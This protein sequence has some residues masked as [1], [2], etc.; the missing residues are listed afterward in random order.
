MIH[1][2]LYVTREAAW[3]PWAVQ[4]FF[5]I[6]LSVGC[7]LLTLP[8]LALGWAAWARLSRLALLGALV[9]GVTAP[10]AL[11]ADLHQPGRFMNFYLRPNPTSWMAWGAFFI[12]LYLGGLFAYAWA[13]LRPDFLAQSH[14]GGRMLGLVR[15]WLGGPA[16]PRLVRLC[17]MPTMAG[18]ALV[19]L[20]TGVEVMVISARPLW[21]TP[22]LPLQF[23]A[24]ALAGAWGL[25]LVFDRCLAGPDHPTETLAQRGLLWTLAAVAGLG[26]IWLGL[27]LSGLSPD[28]A[29]ALAQVAPS[30]RW[31]LLALWGAAATLIPLAMAWRHPAGTGLMTGLIALHSTWMFRWTVFIGGQDIPKTGAGF[32]SYHL[33]LGPDGAL[34]IIGTIGLWV[35]VLV[36]LTT[37]LS[38]T[39]PAPQSPAVKGV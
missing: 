16:S 10:V 19:L 38:W 17:A 26:L 1:E 5:L 37:L 20:Y 31:R 35:V 28:H 21:H 4:Y 25:V 9:C 13:A 14:D 22:L 39:S 36:A 27:A 30:P 33:P 29:Q 11:L 32:Y 23:A 18:A 12:P 24:T 8:G 15:G 2:L 3:L 6:G 7:F 34:G